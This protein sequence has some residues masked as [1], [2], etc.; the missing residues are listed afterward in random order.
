MNVAALAVNMASRPVVIHTTV[1][2]NPET[3]DAITPRALNFFQKN[4]KITA[5]AK[6]QPIPAHAQP[7]I[8]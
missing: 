8:V 3:N 7:T 6:E 4:D 5:G 2:T 1:V